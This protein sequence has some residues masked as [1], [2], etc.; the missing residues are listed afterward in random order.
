MEPI[1]ALFARV[2]DL[3]FAAPL[4]LAISLVYAGTR[5]EDKWDILRHAVRVGVWIGGFMALILAVLYG[6]SL[7]A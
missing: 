2:N 7:L 5:H 1:S 3:W 4:I 6:V